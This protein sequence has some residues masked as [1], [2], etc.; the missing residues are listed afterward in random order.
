MAGVSSAAMAAAVTNAGGLGSIGLGVL[1]GTAA[2]AMIAD[3][4]SRTSG[5]FNANVFCHQTPV[6]DAVLES[7]WIE[8]L[9]P[10]FGRLGAAPPDRLAT[11]F[12]SFLEGDDSLRVLV[13]Q[14]VP[15]V[16]FHFGLPPP[17]VIEALHAAGSVLLATATSLDDARQ[18]YDSGVDAVVA[19]GWEA[20]GHRGLFDPDAADERQGTFALTRLLARHLEVPVIAAGGI[21]DGADIAAALRLGAAAAQLGTAFV[22]TDESLA[23]PAHRARMSTATTVMTRVFSGRPAR[24]LANG[25]TELG[26]RVPARSIPAF[27]V[28]IDAARALDAAA[29]A[30]GDMSQGAHWAGRGAALARALPCA[31]LMAMLE[32][33]L[34]AS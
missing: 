27:P 11:P 21:M 17:G 6:R 14:R 1:D 2:A 30:R 5:P 19:Q 18:A 20:G 7:A 32:Q 3:V 33:E 29:R 24:A 28:A 34:L 31:E 15:V 16:S 4:R 25:F 13:H 9:R 22:A 10:V 23:T 12:V 8:C 26:Q